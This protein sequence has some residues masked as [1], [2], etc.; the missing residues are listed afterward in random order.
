MDSV[1]RTNSGAPL[2]TPYTARG[3]SDARAAMLAAAAK[4]KAEITS[5]AMKAFDAP[6]MKASTQSKNMVRDKI[7]AIRKRLTILRKLYAGNPKEMARALAQVFKELKQAVK[8]YAAAVKSE[9][10]ASDSAVSTTLSAGDTTV[11][12]ADAAP[13]S[14]KVE[15]DKKADDQKADE[16]PADD[17]QAA[18]SDTKDTATQTPADPSDSKPAD[19]TADHTALYNQ[20][21]TT[22]R[23]MAGEDGMEFTRLIKGLVQEIKDKMLTPARI[24]MQAQKPDKATEEA[25]KDVD[26]ALKDLDQAMDDMEHDIKDAAPGVGMHL[27]VAA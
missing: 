24:Q 7:E 19:A 2:I 9:I 12:D 10:G 22:V 14:G 8:D 13:D 6:T 16:T 27:D 18:S 26:G 20:V 25:F 21:T 15:T 1:I 4:K 17:T 11:P 3:M 23:T 5:D